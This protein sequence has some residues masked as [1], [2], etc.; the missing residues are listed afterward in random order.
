MILQSAFQTVV[1]E[2]RLPW[3]LE[4]WLKQQ[5]WYQRREFAKYERRE[6]RLFKRFI[7]ADDLVFD[8]GANVGN[9]AQTFLTLGGNVICLEPD[10][11]CLATLK[12]K[13]ADNP[14]VTIVAAGVSSETGQATFFPSPKAARSTFDVQRMEQLGSD[15]S[16]ET[17]TTVP[18]TTLDTLIQQHGIPSFCKIDVEGFEPQVIKGLSQ[19]IPALSFEFHGELLE[20]VHFCVDYLDTLG[21]TRF[22]VLL[23]PVGR[24]RRPYHPLDR[25]YFTKHVSKSE[26]LDLFKSLADE[27][28]AGDIYAFAG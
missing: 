1:V 8:I 28:L 24:S 14:N 6:L 25:L 23:Y 11:R 19:T 5:T 20:D 16:W 12:E 22:N 17:G 7:K 15:C 3:R 27:K 21:M 13:Y 9:K 10:K 26:L 2:R 18:I 4:N